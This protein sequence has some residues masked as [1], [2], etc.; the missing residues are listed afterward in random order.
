MLSIIELYDP[1]CMDDITVERSTPKYIEAT[2]INVLLLFRQRFLHA[3]TKFDFI[4]NDLI[5]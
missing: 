4:F 2:V 5:N 1:Y 3:I